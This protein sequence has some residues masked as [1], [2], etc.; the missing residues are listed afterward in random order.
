MAGMEGSP[1]FALVAGLMI[2]S[3]CRRKDAKPVDAAVRGDHD[4]QSYAAGLKH[5]Y[6]SGMR[7]ATF[8]FAHQARERGGLVRFAQLNI[9]ANDV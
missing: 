7:N 5:D 4:F 8:D 1:Q 6:F 9:L 2:F 3:H